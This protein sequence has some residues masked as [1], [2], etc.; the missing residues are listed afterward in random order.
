MKLHPLLKTAL[1]LAT[2]TSF[3]S[4]ASYSSLYVF[5]DSL[6]DTGNVAFAT[7]GQFPGPNYWNNRF[8]DGPTTTPS[9]NS[10]VGL[11]VDQL[12]TKL[13]VADPQPFLTN[14]TATNYAFASAKTGSNGLYDISDQITAFGT[15]HPTGADGNAL[16]AIWGG[17][18]DLLFGGNDPKTAADLLSG[19]IQTLAKEGAKNF[20]WMNLPPLGATPVGMAS[21]QSALLNAAAGVFNAEWNADLATL[22]GMGINVVGVDILG[23]FTRVEANPGAYGFTNITTPA[24]G[25]TGVNPN[26]YLFWDTE[27]PTTA[28]HALVAD[29]AYSDL[30]AT[31]TPEPGSV[32]VT[33]LGLGGLVLAG[34]RRSAG[35]RARK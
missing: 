28:G 29:V 26:N 20:L 23:E 33:A 19:N 32:F 15:L 4:A 31:P 3:M 27:H 13:G 30:T 17:S 25:L 35:L 22:R 6:S 34:L 12:A 21:G 2:A 14:P 1:I 5:G 11:W 16:Y 7:G 24:Q 9:T 10:P 18:N 8:T